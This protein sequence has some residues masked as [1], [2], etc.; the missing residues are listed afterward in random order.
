MKKLLFTMIFVSAISLFG[1]SKASA[2]PLGG[3]W[4]EWNSKKVFLG[5]FFHSST[6]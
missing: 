6:P 2:L 4:D 1:I 3:I 5:Q